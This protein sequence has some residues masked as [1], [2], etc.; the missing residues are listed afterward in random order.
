MGLELPLIDL[1]GGTSGIPS[2]ELSELEHSPQAVPPTT[3]I[4]NSTMIASSKNSIQK[5]LDGKMTEL[6]QGINFSANSEFCALQLRHYMTL[7]LE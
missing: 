4:M 7:R 1:E 5:M 6:R 3:V 2:M